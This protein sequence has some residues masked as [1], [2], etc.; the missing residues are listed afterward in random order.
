MPV[1]F[2]D[3]VNSSAIK[4]DPTAS[5]S[6]PLHM[7]LRLSLMAECHIQI[8]ESS[9]LQV[10]LCILFSNICAWLN[11]SEYSDFRMK[12]GQAL[13]AICTKD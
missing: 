10:N 8:F 9:L 6:F 5:Q 12:R 1:P 4:L 3:T 2:S 13:I 11:F 7:Q